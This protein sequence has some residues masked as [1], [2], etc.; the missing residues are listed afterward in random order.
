MRVLKSYTVEFESNTEF[1]LKL[2]G[3]VAGVLLALLLIGFGMGWALA[4]PQEE[5]A[6]TRVILDI[7]YG[8]GYQQLQC[9]S[10]QVNG[11][12]LVYAVKPEDTIYLKL[13]CPSLFTDGF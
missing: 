2:G 8:D 4:G 11:N 5:R 13:Y 10:M 9:E 12:V 1:A 7:D 3:S 6:Q